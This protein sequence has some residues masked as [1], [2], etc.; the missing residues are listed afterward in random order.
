MGAL[1]TVCRI[2]RN[3]AENRLKA[4]LDGKPDPVFSSPTKPVGVEDVD[5][6]ENVNSEILAQDSIRQLSN[7]Q[8]KGHSLARLGGAVLESPRL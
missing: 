1:M 4:L 8:F 5:A 7:A 6:I 2:W 3:D